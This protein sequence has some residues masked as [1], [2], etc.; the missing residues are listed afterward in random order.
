M[1]FADDL[2][3]QISPTLDKRRGLWDFLTKEPGFSRIYASLLIQTYHYVKQSCPL[4]KRACEFISYSQYKSVTGYLRRHILEESQHDIW[5]LKDLEKLGYP[6]ELATRSFPSNPVCSMVGTQLYLME[7]FGGIALLGYIYVLE[8]Y[9][10]KAASLRRLSEAHSLPIESFSTLLEHSDLDIEHR[11]EL[12]G[13]LD[14]DE[15]TDNDQ[16]LISH[17]ACLTAQHTFSLLK[18]IHRSVSSA[19]SNIYF[20]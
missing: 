15:I 3:T 2:T 16:E 10:P 1:P 6:Q 5:L 14:S 18:E 9:P 7:E 4:M 19:S 20:S 11:E 8:A 17:S 12:I 13:I